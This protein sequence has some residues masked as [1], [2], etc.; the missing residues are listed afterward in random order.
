MIINKQFLE[1]NLLDDYLS[2]NLVPM[3]YSILDNYFYGYDRQYLKVK[4]NRL[5]EGLI[6]SVNSQE[7]FD[8]IKFDTNDSIEFFMPYDNND[9]IVVNCIISNTSYTEDGYESYN[10]VIQDLKTLIQKLQVVGWYSISSQFRYNNQSHN[11]IEIEDMIN[12]LDNILSS[13]DEEDLNYI[14]Y[15]EPK[16]NEEILHNNLSNAIFH[17]TKSKYREKIQKIGLK[18]SA[19]KKISKHKP[20]IYFLNMEDDNLSPILKF[21]DR[22]FYNSKEDIDIYRVDKEAFK[23]IKTYFDPI[24]SMGIYVMNNVHPKYL[25]LIKI[26]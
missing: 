16:Y 26:I 22:L 14:G 23:N 10:E 8:I 1:L 4:N 18:P 5:E 9:Q 7:L 24:F 17:V 13:N 21:A 3:K 11:G 12:E 25:E 20:R 6:T 2:S 15:F 19:Q